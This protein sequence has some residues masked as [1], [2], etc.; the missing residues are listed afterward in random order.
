MKRSTLYIIGITFLKISFAIQV[1]LLMLNLANLYAPLFTRKFSW[2][3]VFKDNIIYTYYVTVGTC[4]TQFFMI[5]LLSLQN[6][7]NSGGKVICLLLV[8]AFLVYNN[9]YLVDIIKYKVALQPTDILR[10]AEF[11]IMFLILVAI[12]TNSK[13]LGTICAVFII[14]LTIYILSVLSKLIDVISKPLA[15]GV[16]LAEALYGLGIALCLFSIEKKV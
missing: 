4:A 16:M 7:S 2:A 11:G 1:I 9:W 13:I 12:L 15:I 10:L 5:W 14:A 8:F 3:Q 6:A